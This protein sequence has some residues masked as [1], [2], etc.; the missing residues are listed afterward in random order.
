[1]AIAL[2]GRAVAQATPAG[3]DLP[4]AGLFRPLLADPREPGFFAAYLW[5]RSPHLGSKLGVVGL[6][7]TIG[8]LR[9]GDWEV[10]IAAGVF[11]QFNMAS[12]TNDLI[13][14]DYRVGLPL[15]YRRGAFA[16][17]F[18]LYHQSSHLGDEYLLH[19]GATRTNLTFESA[20]LLISHDARAWRVYG[21]GEYVFGRSPSD[22][23]PGV[24]RAGLEYGRTPAVLGRRQR[25]RPR[26]VAG[27]DV[28]SVQVRAWETAWSM[29]AGLEMPTSGSAWCWSVLL[30]AYTGPT[31]YGQFYRDR[32]SSVGGGISFAR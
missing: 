28:I 5:A 21:G 18:Q 13:N 27:L 23:K 32:L 6:G 16:S 10:A 2:T 1:V 17:R 7:Q 14:A 9:A 30:K 8:L 15:A 20:E 24:V 22:L 3:G 11:S 29:V 12:P 19:T 26:I 4:R 31:P 25:P